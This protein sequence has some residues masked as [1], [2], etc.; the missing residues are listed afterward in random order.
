VEAAKPEL[1]ADKPEPSVPEG[2]AAPSSVPPLTSHVDKPLTRPATGRHALMQSPQVLPSAPIRPDL[3][4]D[5]QVPRQVSPSAPGPRVTEASSAPVRPLTPTTEKPFALQLGVFSDV[6]NAEELRA[7]LERNG[8]KA[9]IEARVHVGPF[10]TRAEADVARVKL[11]ELGISE[12][13][14]FSMKGRKAP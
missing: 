6:A 11:R 2:S 14:L 13:L 7:K 4:R 5:L 3:P 9:S 10:A 1:P 8:I 12:A